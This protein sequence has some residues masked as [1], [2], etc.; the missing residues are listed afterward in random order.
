MFLAYETQ[1]KLDLQY[2]LQFV[3]TQ[4]WSVLRVSKCKTKSLKHL[5][6]HEPPTPINVEALLLWALF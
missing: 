1:P 5:D 2:H 3:R 6:N 4:K